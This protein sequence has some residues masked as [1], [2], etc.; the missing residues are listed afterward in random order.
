[1]IYT[2][3]EWLATISE[4]L[5]IFLFLIKTLNYKEISKSKK[6][7][8]TIS[9]CVLQCTVSLLLDYF[10]K[11][12]GLLIFLNVV[13]YMA[14]TIVMLKKNVWLKIIAVILSFAVLFIVNLATALVT[15][16][17]MGNTPTDVIELRDPTRILLLFITKLLLAFALSIIS[18][19][20]AKRKAVFNISQSLAMTSVFLITFIA[21]VI[22]EKIVIE[23]EIANWQTTMIVVCL[24]AINVLLFFVLYQISYKNRIESNQDL[25]KMQIMNEEKKLQDSIR[26]N[27]EVETLRHDLKNHLLCVAEYI[28]E[29]K[30]DSALEYIDKLTE[31][32]KNAAPYHIFTHSIAV[33]AILD[34]KKL[35]CQENKIDIKYFILEELPDVDDAD[36]CT[37]LSNL[38]DNAI[39]AEMKEDVKEIR[40]S[41][42][43]A[44]NYLRIVI[45]NKVSSSVLE[46]NKMLSTTKD[47]NKIHGFGI[48]SVEN[49]IEKND[50]MYSFYE[51]KG[52]FVADVMLKLS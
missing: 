10:F 25:L 39:E 50:G 6:I 26:W 27:T 18:G 32:V 49:T 24:I 21:G 45:Q 29:N 34:L 14:F 12:E 13:I 43:K 47:N 9:F 36:L 16:L 7:I 35:V 3:S 44:R 51:E 1:M 31:R 41:I 22:L 17:V 8:G 30:T 37:V 15:S 4:S 11:F 40:V 19:L 48:Q 5:I 33:N 23:N 38:L 52:W 28:K 2:I 46:K 20:I 42:K